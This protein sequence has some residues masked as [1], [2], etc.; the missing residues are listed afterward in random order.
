V[1][2]LHEVDL[3]HKRDI[4]LLPPYESQAHDH[5]HSHVHTQSSQHSLAARQTQL[6]PRDLVLMRILCLGSSIVGG[7]VAS[8]KDGFRYGLRNA[9][10]ADGHAVSKL[11]YFLEFVMIEDSDEDRIVV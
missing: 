5:R 2:D 8:D 3:G 9:L 1:R 6:Q 7:D 4:Q 11:F 10:V